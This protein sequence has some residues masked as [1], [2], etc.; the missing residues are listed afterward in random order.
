MGLSAS[1]AY[2][3]ERETLTRELAVL[4]ARECS[5]G[6]NL[7]R[8]AE[9]LSSVGELWAAGTQDQRNRLARLLFA[10]V[11]IEDDCV[12]RV[13]PHAELAGFFTLNAAAQGHDIEH[14]GSSPVSPASADPLPGR[15]TLPARASGMGT[16]NDRRG[17]RSRRHR[18]RSYVGRASLHEEARQTR[19]CA[20]RGTALVGGG[21]GDFG[22]SRSRSR[23]RGAHLAQQATDHEGGTVPVEAMGLVGIAKVFQVPSTPWCRTPSDGGERSDARNVSREGNTTNP[24]SGAAKVAPRPGPAQRR[25]P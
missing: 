9:L 19:H 5:D 11:V 6:V 15:S 2:L 25:S 12:V 4:D 1:T 8:L 21:V 7:D 17:A 3:V 13:R 23:G 16:S 24:T 22:R 18:W 14:A 10:E 20:P